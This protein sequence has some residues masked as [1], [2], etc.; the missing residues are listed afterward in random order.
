MKPGETEEIIPR[1]SNLGIEVDPDGFISLQQYNDGGHF[2]SISFHHEYADR[3]C[4]AIQEAKKALQ[5][6]KRQGG[7]HEQLPCWAES[8]CDH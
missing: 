5:Q 1:Q 4:A 7:R 6:T 2:E 3:V 8:G